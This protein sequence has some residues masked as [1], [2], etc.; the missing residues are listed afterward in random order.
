MCWLEMVNMQSIPNYFPTYIYI[1]ICFEKERKKE[2]RML[3]MLNLSFSLIKIS[4]A[5]NSIIEGRIIL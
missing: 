5:F 2:K 3:T 1:Y 4:V